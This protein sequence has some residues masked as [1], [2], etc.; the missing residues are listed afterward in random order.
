M[1]V[2]RVHFW[3]AFDARKWNQQRRP[4]DRRVP[5]QASLRGRSDVGPMLPRLHRYEVAP[6]A[7]AQVARAGLAQG[8][9]TPST[10]ELLHSAFLRRFGCRCGACDVGYYAVSGQCYECGNASLTLFLSRAVPA[11]GILALTAFL[12]W[13]GMFASLRR[14]QRPRFVAW[15]HHGVGVLQLSLAAD[16]LSLSHFWTR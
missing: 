3:A 12:F 9:L 13:G 6:Q 16:C 14:P 5:L 2:G 10:R 7:S 1:F 4:S 15:A 8:W 11:L